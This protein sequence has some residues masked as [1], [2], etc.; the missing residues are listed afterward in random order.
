M[1]WYTAQSLQKD[2]IFVQKRIEQFVDK[3]LKRNKFAEHCCD[4]IRFVMACYNQPTR[5]LDD[6]LPNLAGKDVFLFHLLFYFFVRDWVCWRILV[7]SIL[8]T[9]YS[10]YWVHLL[11]AMESVYLI[12]WFD[13]LSMYS[14]HSIYCPLCGSSVFIRFLY[15]VPQFLWKTTISAVCNFII[16]SLCNLW[17]CTE[18]WSTWLYLG[19][20]VDGGVVLQTEWEDDQR[21]HGH[22]SLLFHSGPSAASGIVPPSTSDC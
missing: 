22:A 7:Y 20:H 19:G 17:W 9:V 4:V 18:K 5:S 16:L 12:A 10:I 8:S 14:L 3:Y 11:P 6:G 21:Q 13:V 15:S 1:Q 2:Q